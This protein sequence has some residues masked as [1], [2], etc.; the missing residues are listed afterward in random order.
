[1][2]KTASTNSRSLNSGGAPARDLTDR[3]TVDELLEVL[4][5]IA[6]RLDPPV[7]ATRRP[8]YTL[9]ISRSLPGLVLFLTPRRPET[10]DT[11]LPWLTAR[12]SEKYNR[13]VGA[14]HRVR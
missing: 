11:L 1:M 8:R 13:L 5:V 7:L 10:P 12:H 3:I 4:L 2:Y 14:R 6:D 9:A